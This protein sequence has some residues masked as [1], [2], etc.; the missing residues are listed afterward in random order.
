MYAFA[1]NI[2]WILPQIL[3]IFCSHLLEVMSSINQLK[4]IIIVLIY[5]LWCFHVFKGDSIRIEILPSSRTFF[6]FSWMDK[7]DNVFFKDF[8]LFFVIND[9]FYS[10]YKL[11][12]TL[13]NFRK[14]LTLFFSKKMHLKTFYK[15]TFVSNMSFKC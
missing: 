10:S 7:L 15:K 4:N 12:K 9:S 14:Y 1:V 13:T 3:Y 8:D 11:P 6:S 5:Y 2:L